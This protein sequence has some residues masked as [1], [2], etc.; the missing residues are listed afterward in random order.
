MLVPSCLLA[1]PR[2]GSLHRPGWLLPVSLPS[3]CLLSLLILHTLV[4]N[5]LVFSTFNCSSWS[6]SASF[7]TSKASPPSTF[8]LPL[9]PQSSLPKFII[10]SPVP[11]TFHLLSL[12][13]I[14][15]LFLALY[16]S[17]VPFVPSSTSH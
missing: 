12:F 3:S 9:S 11:P 5:P 6:L 14:L 15:F 1:L 8:F 10:P 7:L 13:L 4:S 16:W 17:E 2:V